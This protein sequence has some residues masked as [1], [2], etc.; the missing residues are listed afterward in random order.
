MTVF[1]GPGYGE[2]CY[3]CVWFVEAELKGDKFYP[4]TLEVVDE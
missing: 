3:Y 4:D 2:K 1:S